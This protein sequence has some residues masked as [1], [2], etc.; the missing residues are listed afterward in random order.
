MIKVGIVGVSGYSGFTALELLLRHPNVRVTYVSANNT[1]GKISD[2]WPQLKNRTKLYCDQ[3]DVT[4]AAGQCDVALLAVPHTIAMQITPKLLKAGVKVIDLSGDYRLGSVATYKKW[5]KATHTDPR[6]LRKA[7]Y[8]LPE[9]YKEEIKKASLVANPGCY[10]TAA[11][12]GLAPLVGTHCELIESIIIDAKSGVT[13]AGRKASVAFS[14]GEV[15]ENFK[16]YKVLNHQHVPEI[17]RYLAKLCTHS[18]AIN[19]V[20]HLLPVNRGILETIYVKLSSRVRL[21]RCH[22]LYTNFFKVEPFVRVFGLEEQ[23]E[24]KNVVKTNF[25]DISLALNDQKNL[26]VITVAIDNLVKGAAGQAIQNM[27]LMCGFSESEG[28]L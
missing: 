5:Y 9:L 25:C 21:N 1:R 19:F 4:K 18:K 24:L 15:S 17:E 7:V 20:P 13:G 22:K 23:V 3:F 16:A 11:L 27:N 10:P 6:N 26:L 12:L 28:L 8:G 14:H 2:I